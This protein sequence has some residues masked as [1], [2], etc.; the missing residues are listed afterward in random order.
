[1]R[2]RRGFP[3]SLV[4]FATVLVLGV[5][6]LTPAGAV[7]AGA[8][9]GREGDDHMIAGGDVR[10]SVTHVLDDA[11]QSVFGRRDGSGHEEVELDEN[12]VGSC[13]LPEP[14]MYRWTYVKLHRTDIMWS[15]KGV[16]GDWET[17]PMFEVVDTDAEQ[18]LRFAVDPEDVEML[19]DLVPAAVNEAIKQ[20]Q[21]MAQEEM[22]KVTG[23]LNI[24]GL[25]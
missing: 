19:Q 6:G 4:A 11:G 1:M 8:T 5:T 24:P 16:F 22:A 17:P 23:G 3:R 15:G 12:G 7:G 18:T 2:V 20:S 21:Q 9:G 25:T 10:D 14:G 13:A